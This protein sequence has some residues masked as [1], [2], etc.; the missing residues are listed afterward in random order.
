MFKLAR[1]TG[2]NHVFGTG[3]ELPEQ[4]HTH[5]VT[6]AQEA[7]FLRLLF[8]D[9]VSKSVPDKL[10]IPNPA[11]PDA[12]SFAGYGRNPQFRCD[13]HRRFIDVL[14]TLIG[15]YVVRN[16]D[17]C[18]LKLPSPFCKT[19]TGN[20]SAGG[21][22]IDRFFFVVVVCGGESSAQTISIFGQ[23]E[24]P[25][26]ARMGTPPREVAAEARSIRYVTA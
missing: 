13:A 6:E 10:I 22:V 26:R 2:S 24:G 25:D 1:N 15:T 21:I 18:V 11:K 19:E 20:A 23:C 14:L 12:V 16:F 7:I 3:T 8:L 4:Q 5:H 17:F 9:D